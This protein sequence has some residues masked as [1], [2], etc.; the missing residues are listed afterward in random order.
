M[1]GFLDPKTTAV[2]IEE[3]RLH[4]IIGKVVCAAVSRYVRPQERELSAFA[5]ACANETHEYI[6]NELDV[7][8]KDKARENLVILSVAICHTLTEQDKNKV[9]IYS[10]LAIRLIK[11]TNLNWDG[12]GRSAIEAESIRRMVWLA[13]AIDH[14][15]AEGHDDRLG[16]HDEAMHLQQPVDDGEMTH[17]APNMQPFRGSLARHKVLLLA[18]KYRVRSLMKK[19]MGLRVP[20]AAAHDLQMEAVLSAHQSA[21]AHLLNFAD[22]LHPLLQMTSESMRYWSNTPFFPL[23]V[24]VHTGFL[25]LNVELNAIDIPGVSWETSPAF[26][27]MVQQQRDC[28]APLQKEAVVFAVRLSRFWRD[29]DRILMKREWHDGTER[30][31]TCDPSFVSMDFY[32]CS[33]H[34]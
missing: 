20:H 9:A 8:D 15:L 21:R 14:H 25:E 10:A 7:F 11:N 23:Y 19:A 32:S 34:S 6:A 30:L 13:W 5:V 29:V 4:P 28:I 3:A 31:C 33:A 26:L 1:L 12:C 27:E 17:Y 18:H 2:E 24:L 22:M 16:L